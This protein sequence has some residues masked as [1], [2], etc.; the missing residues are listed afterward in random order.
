MNERS[1]DADEFAKRVHHQ[2]QDG[3]CL[4]GARS[5]ARTWMGEG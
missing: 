4:I 1:E 5:E 2:A 3:L